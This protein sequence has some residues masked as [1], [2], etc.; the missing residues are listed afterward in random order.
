MGEWV[1]NWNRSLSNKNLQQKCTT[2]ISKVVEA[3]EIDISAKKVSVQKKSVTKISATKKNC[4]TKIARMWRPFRWVFVHKVHCTTNSTSKR[5]LQNK[6]C[7]ETFKCGG[8]SSDILSTKRSMYTNNLYKKN[9]KGDGVPWHRYNYKKGHSTK[10]LHNKNC[11]H[12]KQTIGQFFGCAEILLQPHVMHTCHFQSLNFHL[13]SAWSIFMAGV[14]NVII[15]L[16][17]T[18]GD[19]SH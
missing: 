10:K 1:S 8:D 13:S 6:K 15:L 19:N 4:A 18:V 16:V 5:S 17:I 12:K 14:T 11:K 7:Q 3:P 9:L 2:K